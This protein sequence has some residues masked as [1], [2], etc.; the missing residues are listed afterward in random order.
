VI[1]FSKILSKY[2]GIY[3]KFLFRA[4]NSAIILALSLLVAEETEEIAISKELFK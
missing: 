3:T 4:L 2:S 1:K